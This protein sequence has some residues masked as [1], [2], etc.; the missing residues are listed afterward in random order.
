MLWLVEWRENPDFLPPNTHGTA[1]PPSSSPL[2]L[3]PLTLFLRRLP[4]Y[5]QPAARRRMHPSS[6]IPIYKKPQSSIWCPQ[7]CVLH[8]LCIPILHK[9][10][11]ALTHPQKSSIAMK[12]SA[13]Q[14]PLPPRSSP[15]LRSLP[16]SI[17]EIMRFSEKLEFLFFKITD[18]VSLSV[19]YSVI[20]WF[21]IHKWF[22]IPT[23]IPNLIQ[24]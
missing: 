5:Y 1:P 8:R 20:E 3:F 7:F 14:S 11:E 13:L 15:S 23:Q 10:K 18:W 22:V 12:P 24:P 17:C 6:S 2:R 16:L 21:Y 4:Y 19:F 9:D